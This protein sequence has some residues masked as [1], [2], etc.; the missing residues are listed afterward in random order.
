MKDNYD[1]SDAVKKP[2]IAKRLKEE[3]HIVMINYGAAQGGKKDSK[4]YAMLQ[5]EATVNERRLSR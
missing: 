1:F 5:N 4:E 2:E 3:G